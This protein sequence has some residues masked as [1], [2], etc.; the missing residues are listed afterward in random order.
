MFIPLMLTERRAVELANE[1][2]SHRWRCWGRRRYRGPSQHQQVGLTY[3]FNSYLQVPL[4]WNYP[5]KMWICKTIGKSRLDTKSIENY[6]RFNKRSVY[7]LLNIIFLAFIKLM[8]LYTRSGYLMRCQISLG[9][10]FDYPKS[11]LSGIEVIIMLFI[12]LKRKPTVN[13]V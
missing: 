10:E 7:S 5:F 2:S 8:S 6:V 12:R 9:P 4:E 13:S 1:E 11:R 3:N